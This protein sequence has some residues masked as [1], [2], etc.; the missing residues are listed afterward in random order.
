MNDYN[1][2]LFVEYAHVGCSLLKP[3]GTYLSLLA[4][5]GLS[6]RDIR[7]AIEVLEKRGVRVTCSEYRR[8][9]F[10]TLQLQ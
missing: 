6:E 9:Q 3:N 2:N 4:G 5:S 7:R 8:E 1:F 10:V